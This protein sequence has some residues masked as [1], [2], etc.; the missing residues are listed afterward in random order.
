MKSGGGGGGGGG[1]ASGQQWPCDY[2]GEAAAALHCRADAARLCVACDRHVHAANA[3]SR[4]HVRAPLCAGCAARP[5]AA[6]V[7]PVP[8]AV[9]AFLCADCD[10]AAAA[11]RVP[12]E[13]FSGCPSAAELAASWGLDLRRA[14]VGDDGHGRAEDKDGG[15]IDD[16]PFLSVLDYSVLGVVDPDLRDLYVPCDPPRVPAPDA[17]GGRPLRGQVLSDQLAE[18]ARREADT[19]HAHRH[20]DLSPRTPRR[21]SAASGGRLPPGK[22]AP[23]AA[24]MPS[25]HPPPAAAQEV[26][27]PYT[28]LLMM[29]SANCADLFG[30]ADRVVDDDEQLLWDC[31]EPSVP[32][33]QIWDFNL[34]RSR[35]HDEKSALEVGYGSN[36]G[37]FMIKSYSDMLK[38]IS[39]GTMKDLEDIYDSRYCSTAEDTTSSNICQ[40]SSKNVSTV[41]NKRKL[42]SCASTMDGPT[43][44]GNHVPTSGPALT[45]EISFGEQTVYAPAAE[46]PAVRIDSETLAQNRDSAMQRYREKKKNRRYEKHIRYES[47]KLRADTRKRVKGR[48]IKSTR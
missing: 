29:A 18:M 32:P 48:F 8:G 10:T 16:D 33:T 4:K 19:A 23:P 14:A 11:A 13:G 5:A 12:V 40:L 38:E 37:G 27:L 46:R 28:S 35:D 24:A 36:H 26:P 22:M 1:G 41:S 42:S 9:P 25:H 3:L 31:A 30:G 44:S 6:R 20:S 21:T 17:V 15:D 47:R 39:S 45:R 34:G 7:S 43:T 2:C